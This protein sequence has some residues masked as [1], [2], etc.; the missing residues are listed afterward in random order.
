MSAQS[1]DRIVQVVELAAP[2]SRV[3]RAIS[4]HEEFGTW[5][6]VRL[7]NPFREGEVTRGHVTYPGHEHVE[8]ESLTERLTPEELF[9]FSWPPSAVDAETDYAANAKMIVEFRLEPNAGGTRVTITESG[10]LQIPEP[11]RGEVLRANREGWEIQ[12]KQIAE[13]LAR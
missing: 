7:D 6:Q 3:W 1:Q 12:A 4:D 9:V 10:F 13:Y 8:W 5:F 2:P 11:K